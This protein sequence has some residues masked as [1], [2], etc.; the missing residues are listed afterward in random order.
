MFRR[1]T[2][3][4]VNLVDMRLTTVETS[5]VVQRH[6]EAIV[7]TLTAQQIEFRFKDGTELKLA[8]VQ[9]SVDPQALYHLLRQYYTGTGDAPPRE[10]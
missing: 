6:P 2:Y 8:A 5:E 1:K 4:V 3:E 10:A 7:P 9:I